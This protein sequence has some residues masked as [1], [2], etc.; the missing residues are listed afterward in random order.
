MIQ[1]DRYFRTIAIGLF[2]SMILALTSCQNNLEQHKA[3]IDQFAY[4][5]IEKKWDEKFGIKANYK[6]RDSEGAE[7][8]VIPEQV[9]GSDGILTIPE[10]MIIATANS[11]IY[12]LE[13]DNLFA[14]ALDLRLAKHL[15][16][17]NPF[18][19]P[20]VTYTE[21]EDNSSLSSGGTLGF[22]QL[23]ASGGYISAS[24]SESWVE[25]LSGGGDLATGNIPSGISRLFSATVSLPL[26]RGAG[27]EVALEQLTVAEDNLLN[28]VRFFNRF[29]QD[30][31]VQVLTQ[32]YSVLELHE[33]MLIAE[34]N[35][36]R[37]DRIYARAKDLAEVGRVAI[38]EVEEIEQEQILARDAWILAK[39]DYEQLLDEFKLF[40]GFPPQVECK[41]DR[42]EF[43]AFAKM[44]PVPLD[45]T[46]E[47]AIDTAMSLRPDVANAF[48]AV[49]Q[50]ERRAR[51]AG[52]LTRA[53]LNLVGTVNQQRN[54]DNTYTSVYTGGITPTLDIGLDRTIE[55]TEYRRA[56]MM[57][58]QAKWM[59]DE[60][61]NTVSQEVRAALRKLQEAHDR[62]A[63]QTQA[64][65]K[66][67]KRLE[68]T[69]T[70][71]QYARANTRDVLRAQKDA[72]D[73]RNEAADAVTDYAIAQLEFYS[74]TGIMQI[75]PDGM[76]RVDEAAGKESGV[77]AVSQT[78]RQSLAGS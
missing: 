15:Y 63:L 7:P 17:P 73:A 65:D 30:F 70:L 66:A 2:G 3:E 35:L 62:Y 18:G 69:L 25:M 28:Q 1:R 39:S 41:L 24:I 59:L 58:E 36:N 12:Q 9:I 37:M 68:N 60:R 4:S 32:Y 8:T 49:I 74:D 27:R 64:R 57:L 34:E 29:R 56:L 31:V 10:A 42:N 52:D 54:T 16:E 50:S 6:Q 48:D 75:Q 43:L 26:L 14:V 40:I 13:K 72:Y 71:L 22:N 51:V 47:Q 61:R 21:T 5:A 20:S 19:L 77:S 46:E 45:F 67:D 23:L 53:E 11:P 76:W 38:H 44:V 55:K 33:N 78:P